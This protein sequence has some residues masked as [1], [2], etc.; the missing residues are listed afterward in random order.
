VDDDDLQT[1]VK[2]FTSYFDRESVI[3]DVGSGT[4]RWC[5]V[6]A[7]H[8]DARVVGVEPSTAM[9]AESENVSGRPNVTYRPGAADALPVEDGACDGA[10]LSRVLG[11][12]PD[13]DAAATEVARVVRPGGICLIVGVFSDRLNGDSPL[14][15]FWPQL[16][17]VDGFRYPTL[18]DVLVSFRDAGFSDITLEPV[19]QHLGDSLAAYRERAALRGLSKFAYLTDEEFEQGLARIDAAAGVHDEPVVDRLEVLVLRRRPAPPRRVA[20]SSHRWEEGDVVTVRGAYR[21]ATI[22]ADIET[23]IDAKPM[24]VA[25]DDDD[26]LALWF[27]AFT[28]TRRPVALSPRLPRPWCRGDGVVV[29][30]SWDWSSTLVIH[31]PGEWR[32]TWVLWSSDGSFMGWMVD[33]DRPLRREDTGFLVDGLQLDLVVD[34]TRRWR[35][36]DQDELDRAVALG[37]VSEV[38]A[39]KARAEG[40]RTIADIE[41]GRWPFTDEWSTWK[42][43]PKWPTPELTASWWRIPEAEQ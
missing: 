18:R 16:R 15:R 34:A 6:L 4:G 35:W 32:T 7:D 22:D 37:F 12:I 27:P 28:R 5:A 20:D 24:V 13:L 33:L 41:A 42:A 36:K 26:H 25:R 43:D 8:L 10:L 17:R 21:D 23:I 40:E 2:L 9:R 38:D 11:H 31:V 30:G 39:A 19:T 3:V 14:Y 1:W 29:P